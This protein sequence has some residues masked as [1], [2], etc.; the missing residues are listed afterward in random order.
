MSRVTWANLSHTH[1]DLDRTKNTV[2]EQAT[3]PDCHIELSPPFSATL[4]FSTC[5]HLCQTA[6]ALRDPSRC[7]LHEPGPLR[8]PTSWLSQSV[9]RRHACSSVLLRDVLLDLERARVRYS[10]K[11]TYNTFPAIVGRYARPGAISDLMLHFLLRRACMF[12]HRCFVAAVLEMSSSGG[13]FGICSAPKR[14]EGVGVI[15]LTH[16]RATRR[17]VAGGRAPSSLTASCGL[18]RRLACLLLARLFCL[19]LASGC[20]KMSPRSGFLLGAGLTAHD[21]YNGAC[22]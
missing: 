16:R 22:T 18:S 14:H 6:P 15:P 12:Q 1:I 11:S 9:M 17:T 21:C 13:C 4:Q 3:V 10:Y 20:R 8:S 19:D 5:N 2:W 7:G